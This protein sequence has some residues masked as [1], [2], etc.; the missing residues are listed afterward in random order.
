MRCEVASSGLIKA[1]E[2]ASKQWLLGSSG[3]GKPTTMS[4]KE[5]G[6][7]CTVI[8][9]SQVPSAVIQKLDF[10][11]SWLPLDHGALGAA[12]EGENSGA[13]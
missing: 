10:D 2:S 1:N 9:G 7:R 11:L 3:L 12:I 5:R 4:L 6:A 13:Q 8:S